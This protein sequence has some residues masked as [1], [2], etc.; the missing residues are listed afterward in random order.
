MSGRKKIDWRNWV[1]ALVSIS[2]TI[3]LIEL[4]L[5][6]LFSSN[7]AFLVNHH[8]DRSFIHRNPY[9]GSWHYP[10]NEVRHQS[11]CFDAIY[12]TNSIGLKAEDIN[13]E[14]PNIVLLGDSYL[15]GY[16]VSNEETIVHFLDSTFQDQYNFLPFAS[17]GGFG[18]VNEYA[19]YEN[20]ARHYEPKLVVLFWLNYNDLYDNLNSIRKGFLDEE[21]NYLFERMNSK[22][23]VLALIDNM[24]EP[25]VLDQKVGFYT[26]RLAQR[27]FRSLQHVSQYWTN[28]KGNFKDAIGQVYA[29]EV[30]PNLEKAYVISEQVIID[31]QHAVQRDSAQLVI[32]NLFDPYQVDDG[33]LKVMEEKLDSP[34]DAGFPNQKIATICEKHNI[35]YYSLYEPTMEKIRQ[36]QLEFP[37]FNFSCDNHLTKKGNLWVSKLVSE[38]LEEHQLLQ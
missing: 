4:V 6:I 34:M 13:P 33:W 23:E 5:R 16:G 25:E 36:D 26:F 35:P 17:S 32:V 7:Q 21:G 14:R 37:Y 29:K 19:L 28:V 15:E 31:L 20:F 12:H 10:N 1:L 27:G 30:T 18:T 11:D 9:W 38:Y 22:Q 8:Q 2:I 3:G 24:G